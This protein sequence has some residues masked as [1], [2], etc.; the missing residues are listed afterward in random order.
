M[1]W[2]WLIHCLKTGRLFWVIFCIQR[3]IMVPTCWKFHIDC[4]FR[5]KKILISM[6]VVIIFCMSTKE[7]GE[8][9]VRANDIPAR[10]LWSWIEV[11]YFVNT[12]T[13]QVIDSGEKSNNQIIYLYISWIVLCL[14][15]AHGS[16][17]NI[18]TKKPQMQ[19]NNHC[20]SLPF[21]LPFLNFNQ[22]PP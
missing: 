8:Q 14:Y 6:I 21:P 16:L 17:L 1:W 20:I 22:A 4:Y 13:L 18:S 12:A 10:S 5:L 3:V 2:F 15:S 11:T 19:R 7:N 9:G